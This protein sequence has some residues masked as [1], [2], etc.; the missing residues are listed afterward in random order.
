MSITRDEM[1]EVFREANRRGYMGGG[2]GG[3]G[4]GGSAPSGPTTTAP[5]WNEV[6]GSAKKAMEKF[7][8]VFSVTGQ[9]VYDG[10][11]KISDQ[12]YKLNDATNSLG[13]IFGEMGGTAGQVAGTVIRDL[14]NYGQT[15]VEK[16]REVS[17]F[18]AS[19]GNDAIGFRAGAAQT[20][21]SFDE[22]TNFLSK[23][24]ESLIGLGS[25]VTESARAFNSFSKDFFDTDV[26]DKMRAMGYSTEEL[27]GVLLQNMANQRLV[28]LNEKEA[29]G[30]AIRA[31]ADLAEQM[32]AVAKLTGKSRQ[33]QEEAA[34]ARSTDAQ[35]QAMEKLALMGLDNEEKAAR[36]AAIQSMQTSAHALGPSIEGVVKE[37]ATGGVR[38]K[39][40][41]EQMAALG[42]AGRQLQEAVNAAKNAKT[43]E[44]K[45]A[46]ERLMEDA[47]AAVIAQ[48]N[49]TGYLQAQQLGIGAF[50]SGAEST[51]AYS[52]TLDAIAIEGVEEN[53]KRRQ[54][55]LSNEKDAKLAAQL[56]NDRV[57]LEQEGKTKTGEQIEG[58]ATTDAIVKFQSRAA[59]AGAAIN[60]NLV[61]P[62]NE[63]L[64]KNIRKYGE[65]NGDPLRNVKDGVTARARFEAPIGALTNA[66]IGSGNQAAQP[67]TVTDKETGKEYRIPKEL[68]AMKQHESMM[69]AIGALK[70]MDV[71]TL[72]VLGKLNPGASRQ[73]GSLGETGNL[74]ENFGSGTL[75]MLHGRESV[76]TEDQMKNFMKGAQSSNIEGMLKNLTTSVES[77]I[78][79][80][81]MSKDFNTSISAIAPK[82][83][84][85]SMNGFK[86]VADQAESKLKQMDQ[87][88]TPAVSNLDKMQ[89][90]DTKSTSLSDLGD[91][92][93]LLNNSIN[94][95]VALSA[96]SVEVST[97]QVKV[98]KG[99][100][101]NLFA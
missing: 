24:K 18:G 70:Q 61:A 46:A 85:P 91:K 28:N 80:N 27:N 92:L 50:K 71:T 41:S 14:G 97:K 12:S 21:M 30:V 77:G 17:K 9:E 5:A 101:G 34:R 58:A 84:V 67:Q 38:S 10:F 89:Y 78:D 54:L 75:A 76:I 45:A 3:G 72:N 60:A 90:T 57:K 43:E 35:Y 11:K 94:Q 59:D 51:M 20:R 37:M 8:D 25:S 66:M 52:K 23:N 86:S 16:W 96:Q 15:T 31:A 1:L 83:S 55:N 98:T 88:E 69:G 29:R 100:S 48:Q 95:L 79:I 82:M 36:L 4:G 39:E 22:Y 62:L 19:F 13:R 40:A 87:K 56:A 6:T 74:F 49:T 33:E 26:A 93:D 2:G 81:S 64:G 73:H 53:G 65:E 32:D 47:K 63:A 42:P 7:G 99:L 68:G 44:Q